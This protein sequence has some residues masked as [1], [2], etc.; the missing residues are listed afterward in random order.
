MYLGIPSQGCGKRTFSFLFIETVNCG[1]GEM[2]QHLRVHTVLTED[3]SLVLS[4]HTG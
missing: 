2:A 3:R 1:A 4:T